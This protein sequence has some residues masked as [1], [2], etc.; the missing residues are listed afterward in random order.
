[1]NPAT[2]DAIIFGEMHQSWGASTLR[3]RRSAAAPRTDLGA[4]SIDLLE[5]PMFEDLIARKEEPGAAIELGPRIA[6]QLRYDANSEAPRTD[7]RIRIVVVDDSVPQRKLLGLMLHD[8][9]YEVIEAENGEDAYDQI[10]LDLDAAARLQES[11]GGGMN[12]SRRA[13]T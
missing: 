7:E 8:L 6:V 4:H 13:P 3:P 5:G 10:R 2:A 1:M 11:Q 12:G 9:S